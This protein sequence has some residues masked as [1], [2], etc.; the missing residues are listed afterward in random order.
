[1]DDA[2]DLPSLKCSSHWSLGL[3][4]ASV[5]VFALLLMTQYLHVSS[6]YLIVRPHDR[7]SGAAYRGRS[8]VD[9]VHVT[10]A[11]SRGAPHRA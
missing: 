9:R 5:D 3:F 7:H 6:D 2:P 11:S 10:R 8:L 1:M 4:P